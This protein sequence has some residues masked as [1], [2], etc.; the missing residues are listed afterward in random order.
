MVPDAY[1]MDDRELDG[2]P[3][4]RFNRTCGRCGRGLCVG[5]HEPYQITVW[6]DRCI[7]DAMETQMR[8]AD[9]ETR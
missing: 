2:Y 1:P 6:C 4:H 3:D 9:A 8:K 5:R 7:R